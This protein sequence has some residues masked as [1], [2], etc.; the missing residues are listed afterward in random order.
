MGVVMSI[1]NP[2]LEELIQVEKD[3]QKEIAD[4]RKSLALAKSGL[5]NDIVSKH[6]SI[7]ASEMTEVEEP[8][9]ILFVKWFLKAKIKY[10]GDIPKYVHKCT[11]DHIPETTYIFANER[12]SAVVSAGNKLAIVIHEDSIPYLMED[13]RE[14]S[15]NVIK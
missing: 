11:C 5:L 6:H 9:D 12:Q 1:N 3:I 4:K 15:W 13:F 7:E 2:T 10:G 14:W 8:A